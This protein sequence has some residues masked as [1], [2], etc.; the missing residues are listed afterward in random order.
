MTPAVLALLPEAVSF[1][2]WLLDRYGGNRDAARA[3]LRRIRDE[4]AEWERTKSAQSAELERVLK[5]RADFVDLADRA[6]TADPIPDHPTP[7]ETPG[8]KKG[9]T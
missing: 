1:V 3:A 8:A 7:A 5:R 6:G 4:W 9:R 2:R